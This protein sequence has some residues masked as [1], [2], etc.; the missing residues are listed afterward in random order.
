MLDTGHWRPERTVVN[1]FLGN[2]A[3][4]PLHT[5]LPPL[6]R[7]HRTCDP[8]FSAPILCTCCNS[9][10]PTPPDPVLRRH[11]GSTCPQDTPPLPELLSAALSPPCVPG[12][13][14]APAE[15]T[16]LHGVSTGMEHGAVTL[17]V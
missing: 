12:P 10:P 3:L 17:G 15:A 6:P 16:V 8:E 9:V 2:M 7:N 11:A 13:G 5:L 14:T 1:V 4:S